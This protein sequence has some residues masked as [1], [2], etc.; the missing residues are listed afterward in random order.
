[1]KTFL[2]GTGPLTQALD[3]A[4]A[5]A[6]AG[7]ASLAALWCLL[8]FVYFGS[9]DA[10][11]LMR[12][13]GS[14]G[15]TVTLGVLGALPAL[16][17]VLVPIEFLK[18]RRAHKLEPLWPPHFLSILLASAYVLAAGYWTLVMISEL[19]HKAFL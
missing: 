8:A 18:A 7:A 2:P 14:A 5:W 16:S 12:R 3:R 1:M 15:F 19:T 10:D 9:S 17:M 11:A 4:M 6:F 13:L